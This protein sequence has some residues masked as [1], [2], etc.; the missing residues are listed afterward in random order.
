MAVTPIT[1][2][3]FR[4]NAKGYRTRPISLNLYTLSTELYGEFTRMG[5]IDRLNNIPQLGSIAVSK[6]LCKSRYDYVVLQWWLHSRAHDL[7]NPFLEFSYASTIRKQDVDP[8]LP[9][10]AAHKNHTVMEYL[11]VLVMAYN[12]GHFYATFVSSRAMLLKL[13][14]SAQVRA[15][16]LALF[17]GDQAVLSVCNRVIDENDYFHFHL[18]NSLLALNACNQTLYSVQVAKWLILK[19]LEN[20]GSP[21][22]KYIFRIFKNIRNLAL[23]TFDLQLARVPFRIYL[24]NESPLKSFLME[25]LAQYNDNSKAQSIVLSLTKLLSDTIY[26]ENV[27]AI[28]DYGRALK[29]FK[30]LPADSGVRYYTDFFIDRTSLL[31]HPPKCYINV[32][33]QCLKLTFMENEITA[34]YKLFNQLQ[35]MN[36]VRST[37][38]SRHYGEQTVVI[39]TSKNKQADI[40][41]LFKILRTVV[42]S[43]RSIADIRDCDPRY[44][45]V[46]KYF[47]RSIFGNR[48]VVIDA[49]GNAKNC[50]YCV[51]GKLSRL[52]A[53]DAHLTNYSA[54]PLDPERHEVE[55]L[56]S[57]IAPDT[58]NDTAILIPA[59]IKLYSQT[60]LETKR[61]AELDGLIIYPFRESG[62]IVFLESKITR[63][64]GHSE[65]DLRIKLN[66]MHIPIVEEHFKFT[67][68]DTHYIYTI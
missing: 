25:Y 46:T 50:L 21:K 43:L 39:S 52:R 41:V 2:D 62:Q 24:E 49:T 12:V 67:N 59:S 54:D 5:F 20:Q 1:R 61:D 40:R 44:L 45:L 29:V 9:I 57:V 31:N 35:H 56:K 51:K 64:A 66:L 36:F 6:S 53:I 60:A 63:E 30:A 14:D 19:Y 17:G 26:N 13:H 37:I 47:L 48:R 16:F 33:D 7:V 10:P 18:L 68:P 38:Y 22:M 4:R 42:S 58:K 65:R 11:Q 8:T 55:H 15:D 34:A 3:I 28:R 32:D 23:T 27:T